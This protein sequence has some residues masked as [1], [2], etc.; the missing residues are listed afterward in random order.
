MCKAFKIL[1]VVFLS[2]C[3]ASS[4]YAQEE[5]LELIDSVTR[6]QKQLNADEVADRDV[7]EKELL[8]LGPKILEFMDPV[9]EDDTTDLRERVTRI[10]T[11]LEKQVVAESANA[12]TLTL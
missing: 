10:R 3:L 9:K 12:S 1:T 4:G 11:T 2:I 5:D 8:E 6:L 7:A